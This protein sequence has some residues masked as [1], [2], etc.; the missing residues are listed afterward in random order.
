MNL[1]ALLAKYGTII[2]EE[3]NVKSLSGFSEA[4]KIT[5]VYK[6]LWS[7]L[8]AKFGKDTGKIIQFGKQGNT[9]LDGQTL[10]VFDGQGNEWRLEAGEYE[11]AYEGLEGDAMAVDGD[12]IARLDMTIS[13]ELMREG[14]AREFSRFLN[15]MRKDAQYNV[16]DKVALQ[17]FTNDT[18]LVQVLEEFSDFLMGE[19]LLSSLQAVAIKP[20]GDIV[21]EY[22]SDEGMVV[23]GMVR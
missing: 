11:V 14:I 8:S 22:S 3:I 13:P 1:E 6:P 9:K 12:I 10:V 4:L 17:Y 23:F 5:K 15:Q 19:A 20:E 18:L 7:A 2:S 21:S 16:A